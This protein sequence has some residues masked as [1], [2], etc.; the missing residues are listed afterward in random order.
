[1]SDFA[2]KCGDYSV[3]SATDLKL[4]ALTYDVEKE[5][6]HGNVDHLKTAPTMQK[7]TTFY[8]PAQQQQNKDNAP[9]FYNGH[10][11][12][13]EEDNTEVTQMTTHLIFNRKN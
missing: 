1:M 10:G 2:R 7:S 5:L 11:N 9:G 6:H 12:N 3:L 8:N 13:N 4:L